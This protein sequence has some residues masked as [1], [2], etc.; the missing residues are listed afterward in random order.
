[1]R[2]QLLYFDDCPNYEATITLLREVLSTDGSSQEIELVNVD[3]PEAAERWQFRGSP[4]ILIDG[5]DPFLDM[6]APVGLSCRI[7]LTPDG[8]AGSPTL[9][10]LRSA[11]EG[12]T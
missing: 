6:D 11:I 1:M 2:V 4:T 7:Y 8:L 5:Q 3:T 9:A 12:L 10:E